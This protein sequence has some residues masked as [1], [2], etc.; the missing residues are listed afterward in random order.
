MYSLERAWSKSHSSEDLK[1]LRS[2]TNRYHAAVIKAK[3]NF[4]ISLISSQVTNPRQLWKTVNKLL[5]RTLPQVLPSSES[6]SSLSQSFATFFSDKI[7]K[8]HTSL[9]LNHAHSSPHIPSP[10]TPPTFSSFT[11]VTMDEISKLV[12]DSPETNCDLDP[13]P[14][15]L[16]KQCSSVLLPTITNII[17]LS[18]STSIFP[19]Q[20]S[21]LFLC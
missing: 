21:L 13:I 15:S 10:V 18:L 5:H 7:H 17:N 2:A 4:N 3:R 1:L 6:L 8:L 16:L 20:Y 12:S 11:P 14:T 19:D 9:L